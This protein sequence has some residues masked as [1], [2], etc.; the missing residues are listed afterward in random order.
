MSDG[1]VTFDI[2]GDS[3]HLSHDLDQ[4]T[5][6]IAKKTAG[7]TALANTAVSS[8]TN[9]M[10][11]AAK[12]TVELIKNGVEYN[13]LIQDYTTSF[14]TM[15]GSAEAAQ[16]KVEALKQYATKTPF[17]FTDLADATK[18]MLSFG[19]SNEEA[20]VALQH[21]GDISQGNAQKLSS[22]A[23]VY[24]QVRSSGKLMGQDLLQMINA[25]FNPLQTIAQKTGASMADLKAV[26][27]G[28]KTSSGFTELLAA[29]RREVDELGASASEGALLLAQ[30]GEDGEIS[31]DT[32]AAA[33]RIAT[34][35]GGLFFNAMATQSQTFNG[36]L[37]TLQ[38]N[39]SALGGSLT[40]SLFDSLAVDVMPTVNGW[41]ERL[42]AAFDES[43]LKGMGAEIGEI[44][45]EVVMDIDWPTPE[46][47]LGKATEWW[48]TAGGIVAGVCT[49]TLQL[50]GMP[51][52]TA[53]TV[54]AEV[55]KWWTTA[56]NIVSG[57]CSWFLKLTGFSPL[58]DEDNKDLQ[59]W[60]DDAYEAIKTVIKW[61]LDPPE[62]PDADT[63]VADIEAWWKG[64]QEKVNLIINASAR[65]TAAAT[66]QKDQ[67]DVA[68]DIGKNVTESTGSSHA[69]AQAEQ[70]VHTFSMN[71][72]SF[73]DYGSIWNTLTNN[74]PQAT[75][76]I[77]TGSKRLFSRDGSFSTVGE[78]GA[79]AILPLD[80]LWQRLGMMLD[81][82]FQE[83]M[84]MLPI[85]ASPGV[86]AAFLTAS[87]HSMD[88][89]PDRVAKAVR[90]AVSDL[91]VDMDG[92]TVAQ[93]I[94]PHV[95]EEI[96]ADAAQR[97]WTT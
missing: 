35:E 18:T 68:A 9:V 58:T 77:F 33:M 75:G 36:Q 62:L 92:R 31:A 32:V 5:S 30:I 79:E 48:N 94:T 96:A 29:A 65:F 70:R 27:S 15:L 78:A 14:T 64:I 24:G 81:T 40:K 52:A 72:D 13:A 21:L 37:S 16:Q 6:T 38:D 93:I 90:E 51:P 53:E 25:G 3:R 28:E 56:G 47:V 55:E 82:T 57:A 23:L 73:I 91:H 67:S 88:D 89:L 7:W 34:S 83:H 50:F 80:M 19:V 8:I 41:V 4:A 84:A 63:L 46:D 17:A 66:Y 20:S 44:I 1:K 49:W 26:M 43:G 39:L 69:G 11:K 42:Q 2:R 76:G 87:E 59:K 60:W 97:R 12:G 86:P 22:L 10:A 71:S 95:S 74:G 85:T 54:G 45:G 61:V